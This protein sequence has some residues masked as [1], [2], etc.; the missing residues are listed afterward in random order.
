RDEPEEVA[1]RDDSAAWRETVERLPR[2]EPGGRYVAELDVGDLP[3]AEVLHGA[4]AAASPV[5]VIGVDEQT[6]R[7]VAR[8]CDQLAAAGDRVELR[9]LRRR[10]ERDPDAVGR[11][12]V[13]D[14]ADPRR[15]AC[16]VPLSHVGGTHHDGSAQGPGPPA[17]LR[18]G[19][20]EP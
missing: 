14:L 2:L 9:G 13:P 3:R 5:E 10:L 4:E 18:H 11:S 15:G 16:E 7:R 1:E 12:D 8:P 6:A 20:D 17:R 19:G